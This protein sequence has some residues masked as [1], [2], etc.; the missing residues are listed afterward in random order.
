MIRSITAGAGIHISGN[1]YNS[2]YIDPARPSAGMVRYMNNNLE[3]YD[4]T[5]WLP[6]Q[7]SYPQIELDGITLEAVQWVRRKMEQ[8]KKLE[9]LAQDHPMVAD[10]V[11]ALK[12]AQEAV[13]I[14]AA[15]CDTK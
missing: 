4:G 3:V 13:D 12:R 7:S 5:S 8:E 14:A 9:A 2:P 6:M 10:A 15:L 11:A 1:A